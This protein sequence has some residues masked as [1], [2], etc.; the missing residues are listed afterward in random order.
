[1]M[2]PFLKSTQR[3]IS[4]WPHVFS[5]RLHPHI[6]SLAFV[7][8]MVW[9]NYSRR[10][11]ATSYNDRAVHSRRTSYHQI[12]LCTSITTSAF[13][14]SVSHHSKIVI[15]KYSVDYRSMS[16]EFWPSRNAAAWSGD[17]FWWISISKNN[18]SDQDRIWYSFQHSDRSSWT[19]QLNFSKRLCIQSA[20]EISNDIVSYDS[21][22]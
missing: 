8:F 22:F 18:L 20:Y 5:N 15:L 16:A 2:H 12:T 17:W 11:Y 1:M 7:S 19:V 9:P 6:Q 13:S 10:R 4:A 21:I 3:Q 14:S